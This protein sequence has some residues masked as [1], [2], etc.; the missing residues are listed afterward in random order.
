[1]RCLPSLPTLSSFLPQDKLAQE[2]RSTALNLHKLHS[3]WRAVLREAKAQELRRDVAVL[4]STFARVMDSKDGVIEASG[5]PPLGG[6]VGGSGAPCDP[7]PRFSP[8]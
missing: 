7:P 3:Q 1:M 5:G 2:Q 8:W 6:G 4:S